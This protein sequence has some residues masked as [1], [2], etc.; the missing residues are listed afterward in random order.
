MTSNASRWLEDAIKVERVDVKWI[1]DHFRNYGIAGGFAFAAKTMLHTS[2]PFP[3][4][5]GIAIKIASAAIFGILSLV[6]F[7]I[8]IFQ[9]AEGLRVA[10]GGKY[11]F[12]KW[13]FVIAIIVWFLAMFQILGAR[14]T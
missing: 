5:C 9:G 10:C 13:P 3:I 2:S 14:L 1:F 8:N 4:S 11:P 7:A 6:L 12:R